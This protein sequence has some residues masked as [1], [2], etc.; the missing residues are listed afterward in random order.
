MFRRLPDDLL[1]L[2]RHQRWVVGR[3]QPE[4]GQLPSRTI[5]RALSAG[6]WQPISPRTLFALPIDPQPQHYRI[7]AVLELGPSAVLAGASALVEWGWS[8]DDPGGTDVLIPHGSNLHTRSL[9]PWIR[10]RYARTDRASTVRAGLALTSAT[11]AAIDAASWAR[12]D[13]EA[14]FILVSTVQQRLAT[15]HDLLAAIAP[16]LRLRRRRLIAEV[17]ADTAAG[18]TSIP[19]LDF[20]RECRRRG[21]P[22]PRMQVRRRDA[23]GRARCTDAEFALP[24]GGLLIVEINGSGHDQPARSA[25]DT[26]RN[27]ALA[28]S[29][30]AHVIPVPSWQMRADPDPVFAEIAAWLQPPAPHP[31]SP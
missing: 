10:C 14:S 21:L 19:E 3:W 27:S 13:R 6:H 8:G 24:D 1:A 20:A 22:E 15:P 25:A 28:R 7:A 11:D 29:T 18:A 9:P 12:S 4:L 30:G 26:V 2:L 23:N 16:R 5:R 31:A 17:L